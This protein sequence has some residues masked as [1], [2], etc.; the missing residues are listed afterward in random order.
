MAANGYEVSFWGDALNLT[1]VMVALN[2]VSILGMTKLYIGDIC[3]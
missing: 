3:I 2:F 1:V